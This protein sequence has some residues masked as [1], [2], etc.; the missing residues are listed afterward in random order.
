MKK[1]INLYIVLN[2]ANFFNQNLTT[3]INMDKKMS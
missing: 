1:N 3:K 2:N